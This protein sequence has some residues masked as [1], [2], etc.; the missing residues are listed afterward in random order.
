MG[1]RPTNRDESPVSGPRL[2]N[3]LRWALDRAAAFQAA[4]GRAGKRARGQKCP[5]HFI[6]IG[7]LRK[8][9]KC[10]KAQSDAKPADEIG[11]NDLHGRRGGLP[12]DF[13]RSPV[14]EVPDLVPLIDVYPS[15]M[16]S[17]LRG[18]STG[19]FKYLLLFTLLLMSR[20]VSLG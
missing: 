11:E 9:R 6:S 18:R 13:A 14:K 7:G 20:G 8:S 17:F 12:A 5:P 10:S 19:V 1:L 16:L 4:F 2:F 15:D 3:E